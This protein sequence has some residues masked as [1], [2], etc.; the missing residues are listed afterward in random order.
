MLSRSS[1]LPDRLAVWLG[2]RRPAPRRQLGNQSGQSLTGTLT[3]RVDKL[4]H[5]GRRPLLSTTSATVALGELATRIEALESAVQ[6]IAREVQKL[7]VTR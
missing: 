1:L 7:A 3:E 4:V 2:R 6:E 5:A